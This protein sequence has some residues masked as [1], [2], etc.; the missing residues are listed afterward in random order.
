[1]DETTPAMVTILAEVRETPVAHARAYLVGALRDG[2]FNRLHRTTRISQADERWLRILQVLLQK[3][4]KRGWIYREGSRGVWTIETTWRPDGSTE[5][6]SETGQL[7]FARGYFDAEGGVPAQQSSRFYI[8]LVQ[9]NHSDL[10][11]LRTILE[12]AGIRCGRLHN[13]SPRV[14]PDYWRFYVLAASHQD[15]VRLVG[16]WHP[17]KRPLLLPKNLNSPGPA[18]GGRFHQFGPASAAVQPT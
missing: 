16:S 10:D 15:F 18:R 5:S 11:R 12:K 4:G 3:L 14:D 1:M 13:P 8:Q 2:T 6:W 17:R 9:K 7:A